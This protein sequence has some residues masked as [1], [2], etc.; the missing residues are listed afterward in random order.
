MLGHQVLVF[1]K[2]LDEVPLMRLLLPASWW[3]WGHDA[4]L[5]LGLEAVGARLLLVTSNLALLTQHA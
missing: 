5:D 4:T 3:L 2:S 1:P